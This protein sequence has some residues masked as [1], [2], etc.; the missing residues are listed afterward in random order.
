MA[1]QIYFR[2]L[3]VCLLCVVCTYG[4]V[5]NSRFLSRR[6][7]QTYASTLGR[8]ITSYPK[9]LDPIEINDHITKLNDIQD[10]EF[11]HRV[12]D[13]EGL[14]VV[15][16]SSDWCGPCKTMESNLVELSMTHKQSANFFR[17]DTDTQP[18]AATDFAIR[19]IPSTLFFKGGRVV[20]E[21]V[22]AAPSSVVVSQILK[23]NTVASPLI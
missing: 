18:D 8:E 19:S 21:I 2:V 9:E 22:G 7:I 15:I 16:F 11:F 1:N 10:S 4:F 20:S 5:T 6:L 13:T 14:S 12:L 3:V 17:I 23:H